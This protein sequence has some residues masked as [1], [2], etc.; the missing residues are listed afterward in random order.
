MRK[1]CV[2]ILV[3]L[4]VS[5]AALA[6]VDLPSMSVDDLVQ[7]RQGVDRELARRIREDESAQAVAVGDLSFTLHQAVVG[8]GRD[9][10]QAVAIVFAVTNASDVTKSLMADVEYT[11]TQDGALLETTPIKAEG[12]TGPTVIDSMSAKIKPGA[13]DMQLCVAGLLTDGGGDRIE[14]DLYDKHAPRD[15]DPFCGTFVVDLSELQ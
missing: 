9:G 12:Y 2:F 4:M 15:V 7:L 3:F 5:A 1:V 13:S 10:R 6:D 14:I 8:Y 11:I